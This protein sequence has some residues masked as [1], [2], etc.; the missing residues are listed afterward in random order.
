MEDRAV[1]RATDTDLN[2]AADQNIIFRQHIDCPECGVTVPDVSFDTG[3][4]DEDGLTGLE[5]GDLTARVTCPACGH[6]FE[7]EFTGWVNYGDA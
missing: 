7:A 5:P 1:P 3:A 2:K 4:K 6:E